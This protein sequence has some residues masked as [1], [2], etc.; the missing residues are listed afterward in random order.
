MAPRPKLIYEPDPTHT[1]KHRGDSPEPKIIDDGDGHPLSKCSTEIDE[2]L[3][4]H[5]LDTGIAWSP[6]SHRSPL[7]H[8]VFNTYRGIPY[9]A[10]RRGRTRF[11]H[12][13]PDVWNRIPAAIRERLRALAAQEGAE[14]AFDRWMEHTARYR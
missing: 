12:G 6:A 4:Q 7:P 5:L 11:Y 13:F 9:R 8:S 14:D 1:Q 10:H 3:A 2:T